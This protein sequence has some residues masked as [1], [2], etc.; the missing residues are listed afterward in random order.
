[1][2]T[3]R[4]PL[5][6]FVHTIDRLIT[7]VRMRGPSLFRNW[8]TWSVGREYPLHEALCDYNSGTRRMQVHRFLG[9][10]PL[11]LCQNL[12]RS[13]TSNP[14]FNTRNSYRDNIRNSPNDPSSLRPANSAI[15]FRLINKLKATPL[16]STVS[17][18]VYRMENSV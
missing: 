5:S 1:M 10:F 13:Q 6:A 11:C 16:V 3:Q 17:L 2:V 14:C 7:W 4:S 9:V 15:D 8:G 18:R 12:Y